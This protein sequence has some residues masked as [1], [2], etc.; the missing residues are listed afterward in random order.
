[1]SLLCHG[2]TGVHAPESHFLSGVHHNSPASSRLRRGT[3]ILMAR[4]RAVVVVARIKVRM[5]CLV[6]M[7][8]QS[9]ANFPQQKAWVLK[10]RGGW[11]VNAVSRVSCNKPAEPYHPPTT[12]TTQL[13]SW[14]PK[15]L[16]HSPATNFRWDSQIKPHSRFQPQ[17]QERTWNWIP[18]EKLE[19]YFILHTASCWWAR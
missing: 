11:R 1:M 19:D 4:E 14:V 18:A 13:F 5:E 7:F 17:T 6:I 9:S 3:T 2:Y 12:T 16:V 15:V 10:G 8:S